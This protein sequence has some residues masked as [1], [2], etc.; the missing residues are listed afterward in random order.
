MTFTRSSG[1]LLHPTSFHRD[2]KADIVRWLAIFTVGVLALETLMLGS[3]ILT[4]LYGGI[5]H[6]THAWLA[7]VR[8][9]YAVVF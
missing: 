5:S 2:L 1:I 3:E 4:V 9:P 8:G 6:E 7:T